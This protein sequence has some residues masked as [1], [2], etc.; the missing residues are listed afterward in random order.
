VLVEFVDEQDELSPDIFGLCLLSLNTFYKAANRVVATES[1]D[2]FEKQKGE[3]LERIRKEIKT[4]V[5]KSGQVNFDVDAPGFEIISLQYGSKLR[6]GL[7]GRISA[8]IAMAMLT[9]GE[10]DVGKDIKI[11]FGR[12]LPTWRQ[13]QELVTPG[14]S[15]TN[16]VSPGKISE[17]G[18]SSA[19]AGA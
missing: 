17:P 13:A 12:V 6:L 4:N 16:P 14:H 19:E 7:R 2:E 5:A 18:G 15:K 8:L 11:K 3:L 1:Y 9:G 10:V